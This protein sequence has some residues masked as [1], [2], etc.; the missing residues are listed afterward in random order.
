RNK[1]AN[2]RFETSV[3]DVSLESL[4]NEVER[5]IDR[6]VTNQLAKVSPQ[7]FVDLLVDETFDGF[8]RFFTSQHVGDVLG[9]AVLKRGNGVENRRSHMCRQSIDERWIDASE[10]LVRVT[11]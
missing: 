7:E 1:L 9:E 11:P 4:L 8:T 6:L 2:A 10:Q 5:F 3:A